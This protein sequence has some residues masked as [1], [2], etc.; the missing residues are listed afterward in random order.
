MEQK[1]KT[2]MEIRP[3]ELEGVVQRWLNEKTAQEA[4]KEIISTAQSQCDRRI[5]LTI[6]YK[7]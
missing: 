7:I 2:F 1:C 5:N 3:E 6:I 4:A